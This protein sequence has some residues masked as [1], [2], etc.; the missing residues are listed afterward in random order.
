MSEFYK[1][2]SAAIMTYEPTMLHLFLK[3]Y[4]KAIVV[5]NVRKRRVGL[6][7]GKMKTSA[8][9]MIAS[10]M[11]GGGDVVMVVIKVDDEQCDKSLP[12]HARRQSHHRRCRQRRW[13]RW[14]RG[15]VTQC[16]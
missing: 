10:P 2:S 5:N 8:L 1:V 13:W 12:L 4:L 11:G 15:C 9:L 16:C 7:D 14:P 6:L 3:T